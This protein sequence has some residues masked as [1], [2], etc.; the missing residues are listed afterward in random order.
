MQKRINCITN[1]YRSF[2]LQ[3]LDKLVA[4]GE[5]ER[6]EIVLPESVF[7]ASFVDVFPVMPKSIRLSQPSGVQIAHD[8]S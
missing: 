6:I 2:K 5:E 1:A 3:L 4:G 8:V 7:L